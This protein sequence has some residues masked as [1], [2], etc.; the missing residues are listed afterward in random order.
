MG[1]NLLISF[2]LQQPK[3]TYDEVIDTIH[4]LGDWAKVDDCVWYVHSSCSANQA[5]ARL[6]AVMN[7]QDRLVVVDATNNDLAWQNLNGEV[8]QFLRD[9]WNRHGRLAR[10]R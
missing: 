9:H 1:S 6:W 7:P 10:V 8:G 3:Q 4:A 2:S 5:C